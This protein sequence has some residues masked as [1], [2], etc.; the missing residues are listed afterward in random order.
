MYFRIVL[1]SKH[2]FT[3]DSWDFELRNKHECCYTFKAVFNCTLCQSLIII[4][5]SSR[6][7]IIMRGLFSSLV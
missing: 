2:S 5:N 3:C 6:A 4:L 7:K 1:Y